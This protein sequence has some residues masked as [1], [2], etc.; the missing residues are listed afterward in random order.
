MKVPNKYKNIVTT[1]FIDI[2]SFFLF[3]FKDYYKCV[4]FSKIFLM[5]HSHQKNHSFVYYHTSVKGPIINCCII[6]SSHFRDF[7]ITF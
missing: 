4:C 1:T 7:V 3:L 5:S 2:S 6:V